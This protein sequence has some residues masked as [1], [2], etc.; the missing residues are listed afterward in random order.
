MP[1]SCSRNAFV[2]NAQRAAFTLV[3]L[4][5]VIAI[6]GTLIGLLL[7]AV[8]A[9]RESARQSQCANNLKQLAIA[10]HGH[11]DAR[12]KLPPLCNYDGVNNTAQWGWA[13][14]QAPYME[15]QAEYDSMQVGGATPLQTIKSSPGSYPGFSRVAS[16]NLD[17][18]MCVS[19]ATGRK[20][21]RNVNVVVSNVTN[22]R[23]WSNYAACYGQTGTNITYDPAAPTAVKYSHMPM[24]VKSGLSL[25]DITDGTSK[26]FLFG[27]VRL[28]QFPTDWAG[29]FWIGASSVPGNGG[30]LL[31][32]GRQAYYRLN[33]TTLSEWQ[34]A[35]SSAHPGG[36]FFALCDGSVRFIDDTIEFQSSPSYLSP[37]NYGVYQK[38]ADRRDGQIMAGF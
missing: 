4:L 32:V 2:R 27:E 10:A 18:F 15:L 26:T 24:P 1:R 37:Q 20:N 8:Q 23:G 3:E 19:D 25:K 5:V 6:I 16:K 28:G 30:N 14:L 35:F 13:A 21:T 38:L 22:G 17:P 11:H 34:Q 36:A 9:A 29:V 31:D 33:P 7:P 12:G